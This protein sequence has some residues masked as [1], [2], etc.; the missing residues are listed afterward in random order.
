MEKGVLR[1]N[2]Y[3]RDYQNENVR[4]RVKGKRAVFSKS[5]ELY[6]GQEFKRILD[7]GAGTGN[8]YDAVS[9]FGYDYYA[10]E[11]SDYG[12][13]SLNN[14]VGNCNAEKFV[15]KNDEPLPFE[16]NYFSFVLMDQVIEHVDKST[17]IYYIKEIGRVLEPGGVA[18]IRSPSKYC[19]I[20]STD[21]NHVYC[22]RPNELFDEINSIGFSDNVLLERGVLLPWMLFR[23]NERIIDVW[24]K[25]RKYKRYVSLVDFALRVV[26]RLFF[27]PFRSDRLLSSSNVSF[28]KSTSV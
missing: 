10:L 5:V 26:D 23:Y 3:E 11:A 13:Q 1:E 18:V 15:L 27:K 17:G 4:R 22:W 6:E 12:I 16:D 24:H 9:C 2:D 25:Q 28:I 8:L 21:P 14:K 19:R 7:I 20:W